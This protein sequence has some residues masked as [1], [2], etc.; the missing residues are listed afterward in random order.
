M[1]QA[2]NSRG[3]PRKTAARGGKLDAG[4]VLAAGVA[5]GFASAPPALALESLPAPESVLITARPPDPVGNAAFS[6]TLIDA[7]QLRIAPELDQALRQVPGLSLFRRNSSLSA[8]P[9]V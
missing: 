5:A 1:L 4:I 7:P 8:N 2:P 3:A 6:T 9:S